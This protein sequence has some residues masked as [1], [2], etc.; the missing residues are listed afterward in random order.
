VS[1]IARAV[2]DLTDRAEALIAERFPDS[3]AYV[4]SPPGRCDGEAERERVRVRLP[5][6]RLR[7][8]VAEPVA[9]STVLATAGD[10]GYTA[11]V[12]R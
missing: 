3:G 2:D 5:A 6:P 12:D 8:R 4:W 9:R 1:P 11:A 10:R 7:R